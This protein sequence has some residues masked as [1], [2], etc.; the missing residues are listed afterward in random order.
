MT[1]N[2]WKKPAAQAAGQTHP[3]AI[4]PGGKIHP[5]S[6]ST[7]TFESIQQFNFPSRF[8]ISEK[9]QYSLFYVWKNHFGLFGRDGTLKILKLKDESMNQSVNDKGVCRAGPGF[10]RDLPWWLSHPK[11]GNFSPS[12]CP[13]CGLFNHIWSLLVI[14]SEPT[15]RSES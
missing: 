4:P 6:K 12:L 2:T 14:S 3:D 1:F 8:K 10:A 5:F 9:C 7:V 15:G 13:H 11:I